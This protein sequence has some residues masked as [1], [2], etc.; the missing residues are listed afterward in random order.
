MKKQGILLILCVGFV[1]ICWSQSPALPSILPASP[2]PTALA[3]AGNIDVSLSS[4][5]ATASIPLYEMKIGKY[6]LPLSVN[7]GANGL[8]VDEVPSRVGIGWTLSAGGVITRIVR[9]KPDDKSTQHAYPAPTPSLHE[10]VDYYDNIVGNTDW[11]NQPDEYSISAP[12]L[13]GKFI[14]DSTGNVIKFPFSNN[15]IEVTSSSTELKVKITDVNGVIYYFGYDNKVEKT[16]SHNVQGP[17]LGHQAVITALYLTK[18]EYPNGDFVNFNYS[19]INYSVNPGVTQNYGAAMLSNLTT[20]CHCSGGFPP[21]QCSSGSGFSSTALDVQYNSFYLTSIHTCDSQYVNFGYED[22]PDGSEDRRLTSIG[23]SAGDFSKGY[24]FTYYD[25]SVSSSAYS[26]SNGLNN[27]MFFLKEIYW[28]DMVPEISTDTIRYS[29]SYETLDQLPA[30]LNYGQDHFGYYNGASNYYLLPYSP[31]TSEVNWGS[32]Y[33]SA[34]RNPHWNYS[35]IGMLTKITYPTGGLQEFDYEANQ[36]AKNEKQNTINTLSVTGSGNTSGG[37]S[38]QTLTYYSYT[39]DIHRNQTAN[40]S[41]SVFANPGCSSCTPPPP[42]TLDIAWLDIVDMATGSI[43]TE[44]MRD[45][46]TNNFTIS[47]DSGHRYDLKLRV[48]GLPNAAYA[49]ITYDYSFFD[50]YAWANYEAPGLRVKSINNFD[51][52]SGKDFK[53]RFFYTSNITGNISSGKY[54]F[55]PDYT[56]DSRVTQLCQSD[57]DPDEAT[58]CHNYFL[59]GPYETTHCLFKTLQSNSAIL[60]TN[61]ENHI[62]YDTVFEADDEDLVHGYTAHIYWVDPVYNSTNVMGVIIKNVP[63]NTVTS[64]NG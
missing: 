43:W 25:P 22:R 18:M 30:R 61:F 50:T 36:F 12:G 7:Y 9:G 13:N 31:N 58:G 44:L 10:V 19:S 52:V 51:P 37:G 28:L 6:S 59:T 38:Y 47:L 5:M 41:I 46:N 8:K 15:K 2:E 49:Q 32:T 33:A 62:L 57:L 27:K 4:G 64:L 40:V 20:Y 60:S 42:N 55:E 48:R 54:I 14:V 63:G 29:F 34:D 17:V 35:K 39:F 23:I 3:K 53:K 24:H 11:D 16:V 56:S 26:N 1:I 21:T 45:Y